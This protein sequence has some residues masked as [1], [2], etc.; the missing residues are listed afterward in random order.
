MATKWIRCLSRRWLQF[1]C[2][3]L[4]RRLLF[5]S[6]FDWVLINLCTLSN[7]ADVQSFQICVDLLLWQ[8]MILVPLLGREVDHQL[9]QA[10]GCL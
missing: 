5:S 2:H 7:M 8:Q 10:S 3:S 9:G 4:L 6:R 1:N